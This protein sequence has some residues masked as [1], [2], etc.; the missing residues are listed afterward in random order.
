[1]ISPY[2]VISM[3]FNAGLGPAAAQGRRPTGLGV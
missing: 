1:M 2:P 3:I